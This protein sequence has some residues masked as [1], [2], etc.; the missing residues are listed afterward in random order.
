MTR[1][2]TTPPRTWG[3][4]CQDP[5]RTPKLLQLAGIIF[6]LLTPDQ[7][8]AMINR[9]GCQ[10]LGYAEEELLGR[11]W[12][13]TCVPASCRETVRQGFVQILGG[14]A[15][16]FRNFE[17]PVLTRSG[18]ERYIDWHNTVIV[19]EGG[20][21]TE[22]LSTGG[23]I[24]DLRRVEAELRERDKRLHLALT[25]GRMGTWELDLATCE[26]IWDDAQRALFGW[27]KGAAT[28]TLE[29]VQALV[30]PGDRQRTEQ[31]IRAIR[32]GEEE[33]IEDE[34]R[35]LLPDGSIRWLASRGGMIRDAEGR[36]DRL[37]GVSFDITAHKEA[38]EAQ[39]RAREAA[40]NANRAKSEFLANMSHEIRTPMTVALGMVD[41]VL[42][43]ELDIE[44]RECLEM[45]KQA[46]NSLLDLIGDI[47][48]YSRIEAGRVQLHPAPFSIRG[49]CYE[50]GG[51]LME[52]ARRKGISL[53]LEIAENV[54]Q[55]V[56]GDEARI[57][58]VMVNLIANAIKFTEEGK[59][60]V[61]VE[62]IEG[63]LLTFSVTDT[64]IGIPPDML[65]MIFESF[66]QGDNASTRKYGGSGLGL[67]IAK[68]LVE[69]MGGTLQ[70][71]SKV[72]EGSRFH[73]TLPLEEVQS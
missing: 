51:I 72:G 48:D 58:Q 12:F 10:L 7:K 45:A 73:F 40:D 67:A 70:V 59:I 27:P 38:Q 49:C 23:D 21:V 30:H 11:N 22:V 71:E 14:K 15:E 47:L 8:I 43:T 13:D 33:E 56:V 28:P 35:L 3:E 1:N 17:N 29:T 36:P 69:R 65:A 24:T 50:S 66:R 42:S 31:N 54:P 9:R 41:Y 61:R 4:L 39:E 2:E 63:G 57:R 52:N 25:A 18:E 26:L 68:G 37:L 60:G 55:L 34:I 16:T 44:Q 6:V 5:D 32:E 20:K 19:D 46:G 53:T 62:R 64:G